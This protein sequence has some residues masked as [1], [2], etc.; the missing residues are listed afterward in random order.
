MS[1][2]F[3]SLCARLGHL[4][5]PLGIPV[6]DNSD[7]LRD[8]RHKHQLLWNLLDGLDKSHQG[9]APN[10]R[11]VRPTRRHCCHLLH[12]VA[13][14]AATRSKIKTRLSSPTPTPC[15]N[16]SATRESHS[17][18]PLSHDHLRQD[19]SFLVCLFLCFSWCDIVCFFLCC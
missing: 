14:K 17:A 8:L 6:A 5:E 2:L 10:P 18:Q 19:G 11:V 1:F 9:N 15:L 3:V 12:R 4:P 13:K 7:L 16:R